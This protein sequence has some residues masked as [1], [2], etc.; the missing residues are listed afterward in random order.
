MFLFVLL[1]SPGAPVLNPNLNKPSKFKMGK[2][3]KNNN[4]SGVLNKMFASTI[5]LV[6][7]KRK[8]MW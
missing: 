5:S 7:N 1:T 2:S 8:D 3:K 6:N 4:Y